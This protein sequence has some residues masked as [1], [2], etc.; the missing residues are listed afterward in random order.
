[1]IK[2]TFRKL[3]ND[4]HLWLGLGS[5]IILFL[6]CFSGTL[7]TFE[8]EIKELFIEEMVVK[9]NG[10]GKKSISNLMQNLEK[11]GIVNSVTISYHEHEPYQFSVKTDPNQRRGNTYLVNP[12]TGVYQQKQKS[13]LDGFFMTMFRMHRW[14]LLDSKIGRPIVGVATLIFL[15]LSISGLYLWFP[16]KLKWKNFKSGFKVKFSANWKRINHDLHNTLGFYACVYLVIMTLT[17]LCWSFEWYRDASSAV[18]GTKVFGSRGGG[19]KFES[20]LSD[21]IKGLS[22]EEIM[23]ISNSELNYEGT[24]S[25]SFVS[26]EKRV[27][28]IAKSN[29][30]SLSPV[31]SDKL[32]LDRDGTVLNK[33]LFSDKP[34]NVQIASLIKPIHTGT[35]FGWFSKTIY[36]IT[37]LIAT[38]LPI[39]G[40]LI[41]W[42][43]LQKKRKK[44][45]NKS[46]LK[47]VS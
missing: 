42:N 8:D 33:E 22:L 13:S 7:L 19:P 25:L 3:M 40:T 43:K 9:S 23:K 44:K 1:M 10:N 21:T 20:Q 30:S 14:L 39:T 32:I 36:F 29:A 17:G 38:S 45:C 18:L 15:F 16:K 26:T 41:W 47:M 37:C 5:G 46:P 34:L 12:Y 31:T 4:L 11:E 24:T 2:F 28:S 35:I 6:V 27:Y